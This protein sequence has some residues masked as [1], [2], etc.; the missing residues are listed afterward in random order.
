MKQQFTLEQQAELD[1]E[2]AKAKKTLQEL[3]KE[4]PRVTPDF[5]LKSGGAQ[6]SQGCDK[7]VRGGTESNP[8]DSQLAGD[9]PSSCCSIH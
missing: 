7:Y 6:S 5:G 9:A 1:E 2:E 4:A 8:N 3:S